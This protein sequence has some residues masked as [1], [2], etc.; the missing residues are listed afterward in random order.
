LW[1]QKRLFTYQ[2]VDLYQENVGTLPKIG[3]GPWRDA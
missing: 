3:V 1:Q 2:K